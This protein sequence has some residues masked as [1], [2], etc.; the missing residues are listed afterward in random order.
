[1]TTIKR[2]VRLPAMPLVPRGGETVLQGPPGPVGP[3]GPQ[4][5]SGTIVAIP[6][7][8]W[9]PIDPQPGTLYLRLAP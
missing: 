6:F 3:Q 1:M 4:G 7:A 8:E 9:P 2:I 5:P